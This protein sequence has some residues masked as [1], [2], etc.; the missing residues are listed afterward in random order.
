LLRHLEAGGAVSVK[1]VAALLRLQREIE[2]DAARSDPRWEAS[3]AEVLWLARRH[4]GEGW[5]PFAADLRASQAL[6]AM[7]GAPRRPV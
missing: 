6:Q 3:L 4:L 1:D 5:E 2:H 7:W